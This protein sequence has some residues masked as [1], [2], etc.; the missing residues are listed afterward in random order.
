MKFVQYIMVD[1]TDYPTY[2]SS[3]LR[4]YAAKWKINAIFA[5]IKELLNGWKAKHIL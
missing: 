2:Q 4:F 5:L 1:T 3:F